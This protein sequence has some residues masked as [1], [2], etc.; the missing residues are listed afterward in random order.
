MYR[1]DNRRKRH[2]HH[3]L[4]HATGHGRIVLRV[5]IRLAID[6]RLVEVDRLC[7]PTVETDRIFKATDVEEVKRLLRDDMNLD[8]IGCRVL[9]GK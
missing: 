3:F 5:H 2:L 8:G 6:K 9:A 7:F 1:S 4:H